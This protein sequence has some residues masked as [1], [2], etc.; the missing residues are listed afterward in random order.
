MSQDTHGV[1]LTQ[2]LITVCPQP[3]QRQCRMTLMRSHTI[4]GFHS[5]RLSHNNVSLTRTETDFHDTHGSHT[6]WGRVTVWSWTQKETEDFPTERSLRMRQG[7]RKAKRQR[8]L[9]S[10]KEK[11]LG[12]FC[13]RALQKRLYSAKETERRLRIR[14][15]QERPLAAARGASVCLVRRSF[16]F[17]GAF[18]WVSFRGSLCGALSLSTTPFCGPLFVGLSAAPSLFLLRLSVDLFLRVSLRC[19][20]AAVLALFRYRCLGTYRWVMAHIQ[21][22]CGAHT[23]KSWHT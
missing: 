12:L 1:T 7:H 16:F 6:T 5:V 21:T 15:G 18:L 9:Y 23:N 4:W 20:P 10:A 17:Y 8:R 22:S 2:Y 3:S 19:L 14:E 11:I 13:K